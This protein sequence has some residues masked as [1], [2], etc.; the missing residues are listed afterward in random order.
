MCYPVTGGRNVSRYHV[1]PAVKTATIQMFPVHPESTFNL[2]LMLHRKGLW[3]HRE[4]AADGGFEAMKDLFQDEILQAKG[5]SNDSEV[6]PLVESLGVDREFADR[7]A[8]SQVPGC[9]FGC[10]GDLSALQ[11]LNP[12]Q[13]PARLLCVDP[14]L[15]LGVM[16]RVNGAF[17][18]ADCSPDYTLGHLLGQCVFFSDPRILGEA[19]YP[20]WPE[21][22]QILSKKKNNKRRA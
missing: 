8:T 1:T 7:A 19:L 12:D 16:A 22:P 5:L 20:L 11:A 13:G 9:L 17:Y 10:S 6:W 21:Q 15:C 4:A 18:R 3:K 14:A 2:I